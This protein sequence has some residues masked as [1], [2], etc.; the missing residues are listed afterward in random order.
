[1]RCSISFWDLFSFRLKLKKKIREKVQIITSFFPLRVFLSK[2]DLRYNTNN[3][4]INECAFRSC[5][6]CFFLCECVCVCICT[7]SNVIII[8]IYILYRMKWKAFKSKSIHSVIIIIC[9]CVYNISIYHRLY[10]SFHSSA[11][12]HDCSELQTNHKLYRFS[13]SIQ[14][15]W[16]RIDMFLSFDFYYFNMLLNHKS[17]KWNLKAMCVCV[18][19]R[20]F[21]PSKLCASA[22]V[23]CVLERY[24]DKF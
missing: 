4:L 6:S 16:Y 10:F 20:V 9:A 5:F 21:H 17:M 13:N 19:V 1:M 22:C 2:N 3:N 8:Y 18:Y 24:D 7:D 11:P 23:A 14:S 15:L 12:N